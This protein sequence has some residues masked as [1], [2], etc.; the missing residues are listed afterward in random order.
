[1]AQLPVFLLLF[2]KANNIVFFSFL[3][4][5]HRIYPMPQ[6]S[7]SSC[8]GSGCSTHLTALGRPS[9]NKSQ[10]L[11]FQGFLFFFL[12]RFFCGII[13]CILFCYFHHCK[14]LQQSTKVKQINK[15]IFALLPF[16]AIYW[17]CIWGGFL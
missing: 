16:T 2:W 11:Q 7:P 10:L 15:Y 14:G 9:R 4:S 8:N 17:L 6:E 12:N 1:M 5:K 3:L 13:L